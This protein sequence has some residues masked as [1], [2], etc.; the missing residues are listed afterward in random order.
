[1]PVAPCPRASVSCLPSR[2]SRSPVDPWSNANPFRALAAWLAMCA[3][4]LV[5][6]GATPARATTQEVRVVASLDDAEQFADLS[7]YYN[8]SDLELVHDTSDQI[9]G[10][11]FLGLAI[12]PGS[13][14]TAAWIQFS[15]KE[16]QS[17]VTN[18]NFRAQAA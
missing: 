6:S 2:A 18:L 17:E 4:L 15:A 16:S 11:R 3:A 5:V 12:P 9:V 13:T 14:I 7:M 8:S 1:M 10:M